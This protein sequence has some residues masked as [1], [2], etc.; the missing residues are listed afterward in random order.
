[1]TD[2]ELI[3]QILEREVKNILLSI[4]PTFA[5]FSPMACN[6]IENFIDPYIDA[7]CMGT[8]RINTEAAGSFI[9]T[10]VN[11]KVDAFIKQFNKERNAL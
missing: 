7:F 5:M 10:E 8:S 2:K 6:A 4:N 11:E 9:K 3:Y 1:M